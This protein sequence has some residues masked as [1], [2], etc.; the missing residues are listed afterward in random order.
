[1]AD[2][3]PPALGRVTLAPARFAVARAATAR[4]AVRRGSTVRFALSEPAAVTL[5]IER[6]AGGRRRAAATLRRSARA[7]ANRVRFSGRIGRRA[8]R[9]GR[10]RLTVRAIDGAGNRSAARRAVFHIVR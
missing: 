7:G 1:L 9:R 8:L 6:L 4:T 10:Y 2:R 5:R 3:T